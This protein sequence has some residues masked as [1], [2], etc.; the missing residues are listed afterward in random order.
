V[1]F[2]GH[3]EIGAIMASRVL[4]R[5]KFPNEIVDDISTIVRNHMRLGSAVPFT[6]AAARRLRRDLG[7]LVEPLIE[8]CEADAT[9]LARIP[10]GIDFPDVRRK[11]SEVGQSIENKTFDSPLS[12]GEIMQAANID[13]GEEVGRLKR[14][15]SDAVVD[16]RIAP[17]DKQ[18]ALNLLQAELER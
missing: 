6:H 8:V 16:G 3:E 7:V 10:K 13:P 2:F 9:A 4:R 15:L 17:D 5:L 18:A 11:L 1:R 14:L 12:G